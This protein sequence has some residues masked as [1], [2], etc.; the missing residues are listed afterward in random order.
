MEALLKREVQVS[1]R[2]VNLLEHLLAINGFRNFSVCLHDNGNTATVTFDDESEYTFFI[3]KDILG[4]VKTESGYYLIEPDFDFMIRLEKK[5]KSYSK[6][7]EAILRKL[8]KE[9]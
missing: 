7:D 4:K 8:L 9:S 3:L 2:E 1:P 6:F 5:L